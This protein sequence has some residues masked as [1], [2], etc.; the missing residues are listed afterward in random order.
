MLCLPSAGDTVKRPKI[1]RAKIIPV[2]HLGIRLLILVNIDV[3]WPVYFLRIE[4][5][6]WDLDSPPI[7]IFGAALDFGDLDS[8]GDEQSG[9]E[10]LDLAFF[11]DETTVLLL[12]TE[13][14][15]FRPHFTFLVPLG[16]T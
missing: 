2:S 13:G 9:V 14:I 5:P 4:Y 10:L 1:M 6:G 8:A 3:R 7:A 11:D 16:E 12:R 15:Y